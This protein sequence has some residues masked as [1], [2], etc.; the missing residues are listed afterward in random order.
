MAGLRCPACRADQSLVLNSRPVEFWRW[1]RRECQTC[2]HI[3]TTVIVE[4]PYTARLRETLWQQ[5]KRHST[6]VSSTLG[7]S[8]P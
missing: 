5:V 2:H 6:A 7:C 8:G 4:L 3:W 1:R